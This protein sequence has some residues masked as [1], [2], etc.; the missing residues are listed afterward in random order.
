MTLNTN[1]LICAALFPA[2]ALCI[3]VFRKDRVDKEPLDLLIKLFVLGVVSCFPAAML[4]E[5]LIGMI[6][7]IFSAFTLATDGE[8][9]FTSAMYRIYTAIEYFIGVALVEEGLKWLILFFVTRRNRNFNSLFDGLI[10][11]VFVSLGFAALENVFYV[12]EYGWGNALM[13][14]VM[15]VPGHMFFA[16]LMGYYYSLW[17]M[18]EKAGSQEHL[19]KEL[20]HLPGD[21]KEFSGRRF[22]FLSLLIPI[23]AHG[24]Y[25]YCCTIDTLIAAV[26]L[27]AFLI[28]LYIYCFGKIRR[29][30]KDDADDNT[31]ATAMVIK[32]Y[33]QLR[34]LLRTAK[35]Q[36]KQ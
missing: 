28:F 6:D 20:G 12:L 35:E 21:A 18:Y 26:M 4:E 36:N 9:Y 16:V 27:Y 10:Y 29:M 17:H 25:N 7:K 22:I 15:S 30:S 34:E 1:L 24:W 19:L 13:R 11:A 23:L 3:Y 2:I 14:A 31:Y 5:M 33:P 32:K 8:Y